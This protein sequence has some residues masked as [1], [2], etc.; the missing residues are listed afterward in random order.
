M[1]KRTY[2]WIEGWSHSARSEWV[3]FLV[4][5]AESSVFPIPPDVML[6]PMCGSNTGKALRFAAICGAG[7]VLGGI[8]GYGIGLFAF[9]AVGEPL[10]NFYDPNHQVFAQIEQIYTRWGFWGVLT[11]AIT[12]I[13]YKLFT[14]ASGLFHFSFGLFV[15]A[16]VIGRNLRY[17]AVAGL[18]SWGGDRLRDWMGENFELVAGSILV[19]LVGS[20]AILK[21]L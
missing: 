13:P 12:P 11:A 15:L 1:L 9:D 21:F 20:I 4:A 19:F 17:F 10:L 16:S 2:A 5:I 14:L 7:S 6:V 3:L 8:L 18:M